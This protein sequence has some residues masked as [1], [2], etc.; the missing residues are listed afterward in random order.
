[1]AMND[2]ET[3]ALIAGG[4]TFGK[5]H[6]AGVPTEYV[7]PEPEAASIEEQGLGWKNKLGGGH[8]YHTITSGLEGA[9]TTNP[10]KWD[11]NFFENLF[12]YEWEL[13]KSPAGANQWTPKNGAGRRYGSRRAR[14][15]EAPRADD[16]DDRPRAEDRSG[17]RADREAFL[18]ASAGVRGRIRQG[19]VQADAP[20]YGAAASLS[21]TSRS[22]RAAALAGS[23]ACSRSCIDR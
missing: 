2:E 19:L 13:T 6:G 5:T 4:H 7:G 20:R 14:Q 3:V 11:N 10:I 22:E 21:R 15:G 12:G 17:L 18:R 16:G 9:W 1:M 8:G 23:C